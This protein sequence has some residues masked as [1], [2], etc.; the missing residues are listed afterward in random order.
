MNKICKIESCEKEVHCKCLCR[1]HY[2][3]QSYIDNKEK[4]YAR[5][6]KWVSSHREQ[7]GATDKKFKDSNKEKLTEYR[8]EYNLKY[9][10]EIA[11]YDHQYY[12]NHKSEKREAHKLYLRKRRKN[13][14]SFKL[15]KAVS[16]S[17]NNS[18]KRNGNVKNKQSCFDYLPYS[19]EELKAHLESQFEP[20]MTW[21][22]H[23]KY[24]TNLWDDNDV[25]TWT[26]NVD[27]IIPQSNLPF[28]SMEDK[29]FKKCWALEN[30]R[31]YSS[32]Q[33]VLDKNRKIPT[34]LDNLGNK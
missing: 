13:D 17:I 7:V 1:K 2:D 22:N 18:M 27:H 28:V 5:K 20:W 6:K 23:G 11:D 15:R 24:D 21:D 4:M 19:K 29:N 25:N 32:K 33:N 30:L 14:L 9:R 10:D 16:T 12:L 26:W 8:K 3:K 34:T 31:P